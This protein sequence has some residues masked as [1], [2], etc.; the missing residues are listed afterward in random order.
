M[1]S[2]E[3][4][5]RNGG[6]GGTGVGGGGDRDAAEN[7]TA[8]Q[9]FLGPDSAHGCPPPRPWI[10]AAK[11]VLARRTPWSEVKAHLHA[12]RFASS[13]CAQDVLDWLWRQSRSWR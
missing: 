12:Y 11:R 8:F 5:P 3:R 4:R 10:P 1:D 6:P 7:A 9:I 13:A 2:V